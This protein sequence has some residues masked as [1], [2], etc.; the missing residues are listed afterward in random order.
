MEKVS[1][2][3][4]REQ[5]LKLQKEVPRT[6]GVDVVNMLSSYSRVTGSTGLVRAVEE[7]KEALENA[8]LPAKVYKVEN[9]ARRGFIETPSGWDPVEAELVI[10]IG[11]KVLG[12]FNL[13]EHPTL[14]SAH[15]P[16]GEGCGRLVVCERECSGE[17]VLTDLNPY[18]AYLTVDA[19]LILHYDKNR[20]HEAVPYT[21]LFLKASEVKHGKVV[22]NIPYRLATDLISRLLVNPS[23][24]VEVCWKASVKFHSAGLPVLVSCGGRPTTLIVSHVCHPKPGAHDNASGSAANF[25]AAFAKVNMRE[26]SLD[27]VCHVWVPEYT[28]TVFL[29]EILGELPEHVVNLDMVGSKQNVTGSVLS[30]V[31]P[32]LFMPGRVASAMY[33]SARSVLDTVE[34]FEGVPQPSV[35][36]DIAPYSAGSDH[37]VFITWGVDSGMLNEWPSKYYHTDMDTPDT[38]SPVQ[39]SNTAVIALLASYILSDPGLSERANKAYREY[40]AGWYS[41]KSAV[42][43][44]ETPSLGGLNVEYRRP[45]GLESPVSM[46][47]IYK[48]LGR[49]TFNKVRKI[50]GAY[51][52]LTVYAPVAESIGLKDHLDR[53][54]REGL[55]EWGKEEAETVA[56]VWD[57]LKAV[58]GW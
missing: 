18:D 33:V 39:L 20:F 42:M 25:L 37:D 11:E 12:R 50:K 41:V 38:I 40:L 3:N 44:V 9:N 5:V 46:R 23:L 53:F 17:V 43:G 19:K 48:T 4:F 14:L 30:V 56:K 57:E 31:N 52:Y 35:R 49:D 22:M 10:R 13:L 26:P 8:G 54:V 7:L 29:K 24:E 55:V 1:C 28:G 58:V 27:S 51:S 47:F 34:S 6:L 2:T 16:G 21:G 36:Y 45:A 32:P 15:S